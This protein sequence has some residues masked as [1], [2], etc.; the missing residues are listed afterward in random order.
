NF[1]R[2]VINCEPDMDSFPLGPIQTSP[3]T[4]PGGPVIS[5]FPPPSCSTVQPVADP[6]I[7]LAQLLLV[8]SPVPHWKGTLPHKGIIRAVW[9][10]KANGSGKSQTAA[11][12]G[13]VM[14]MFVRSASPLLV[15]N[16]L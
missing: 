14:T 3:C 6:R 2:P 13:S 7:G 9:A 10:G 5:T 11:R 1:T 12:A 15:T 4:L 8:L 16:T